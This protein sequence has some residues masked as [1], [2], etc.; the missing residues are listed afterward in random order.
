MA[1]RNNEAKVT[2][3]AQTGEF[4]NAIK[5]ANTEMSRLQAELRLN[6][7]Q[8]RTTGETAEGLQK[9]HELLSAQLVSAHDKTEALRKK[10]EKAKEI[11]GENS[12]EAQRLE[13]QL[14][15]AQIAEERIK[16]SINECNTAL[17]NQTSQSG[18][19]R[20][21]LQKLTDKIGD[22]QKE[23]NRLKDEYKNA[24]LQYGEASTEASNLRNDISRLSG[25]LR[26]NQ[27]RLSEV[28]SGA[29]ELDQSLQ[30]AGDSSDDASGGFTV[31]K[32]VIADLASQAI[33]MAIGKLSEFCSWL[34][35]LPEQTRELRQD[36][37]TLETAFDNM[38]FN[39]ETATQT[40]KELYAVFGE[41][42]RAVETANNIT[43][44][45]DSQKDLNDWVTITTGV[46]GTYQ[47]S[48]PVEGLAEASMETAKTGTVTG[49]LAD[50]LNWSSEAAKMF[51]GYMNDEVVTAE[52]AFNVALSECN[53]EQERQQLITDTLTKLYGD[54]AE[55]YRD[56]AGAQME[57]KEAIAENTLAETELAEAVEPVTTEFTKLKTAL[58]NEFKPAIEAVTAG[59]LGAI[60]WAKEHPTLMK[61]IA[62][63]VGVLAVGLSGLAIGIGI[64][65][66]AQWAMNAAMLANPAVA[67]ITA[68]I[69]AIAALVAAIIIIVDNWDLIKAKTA[70]VWEK[71][72]TTVSNGINAVKTTISNIMTAIST[73][74]TNVWN[75]IKSGISN[76]INAIKTA[77]S[78]GFNSAKNTITN[79]WN[80][81]KLGIEIVWNAIKSAVSNAVNAVKTTVS[82]VFNAVKNTVTSIWNS[83]KSSIDSVWNG[84]K[85][86]VSSAVNSVKSTVSNVFNG[87]KNTAV[88]VWNG[89]KNAITKPIEEAKNKVKSVVDSIKG[90]FSGMKLEFPKIKMPHFSVTG[91]F[92]LD[93]PSVPK[94]GIEWYKDGGIMMK[95]TIFGMNG[96]NLM[97]GGEAGAEAILPI[98]KLE[99]Y[100][101]NVVERSVSVVNLQSLA[102]SIEDLANRPIEF[103]ING[104][105]F[106]LATASDG[107]NVNGL[108][109]TFKSRGLVLD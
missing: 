40:W 72:K 62:A 92:S 22:Q 9:R 24:V 19:S 35:E 93:P 26:E 8:M 12:V 43:K 83:I 1:R 17:A 51:A 97:A 33:Q 32:G 94:L 5:K 38:G 96:N 87:I 108:R 23:L 99:G 75:G 4:N 89:V 86:G 3:T 81:I 46:W 104:R 70:E 91:K 98:E 71:I 18:D 88:S 95:P 77:V 50:A 14:I 82:N 59:M 15:N 105:Q 101:A 60:E 63:A 25:E 28:S 65:T 64:Y 2:F 85:S 69:A 29:D 74:F 56:T 78:N 37:A 10:L 11:F 6:A 48:L 61:A 100:I 84:I 21:E 34:A 102:D 73:F 45:A 107:D 52:D 36:F 90:F 80:A 27:D 103:N 39:T 42:D 68:I 55:K 41:D 30:N 44:M 109:S 54:A 66:A 13:A 31:M 47:D 16:Q 79:I 67:I 57:A 53:T 106:A 49:G 58:L 7:E 20:N 76:A